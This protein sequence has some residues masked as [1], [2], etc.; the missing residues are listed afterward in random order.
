MNQPSLGAIPATGSNGSMPPKAGIS[1]QGN[2]TP[3]WPRRGMSG[4]CCLLPFS[5][6][7]AENRPPV[8]GERQEPAMNGH[9]R[10]RRF[11]VQDEQ[12]TPA[13]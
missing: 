1:V 8:G 2:L 12:D 6:G 9:S 5:R 3:Q 4:G 13:C 10:G 11:T 7:G